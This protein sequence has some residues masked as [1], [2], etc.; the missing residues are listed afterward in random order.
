MGIGSTTGDVYYYADPNTGQIDPS[1][2]TGADV[3]YSAG[4]PVSYSQVATRSIP[5]FGMKRFQL[6]PVLTN[7]CKVAGMCGSFPGAGSTPE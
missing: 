2:M 6:P 3:G 1:K 4:L 7:W 5:L